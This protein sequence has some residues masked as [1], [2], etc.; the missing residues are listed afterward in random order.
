MPVFITGTFEAFLAAQVF[1][2]VLA[3]TLLSHMVVDLCLACKAASRY[4]PMS[5]PAALSFSLA[6]CSFMSAVAADSSLMV[7]ALGRVAVIGR[8]LTPYS[9]PVKGEIGKLHRSG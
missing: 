9:C 2:H 8:G 1:E 7:I 6:S 4:L 5:L 3:L